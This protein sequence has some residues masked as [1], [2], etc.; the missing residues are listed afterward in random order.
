MNAKN[1]P[2][3]RILKL[4]VTTVRDCCVL[5]LYSLPFP[6]RLVGMYQFATGRFPCDMVQS[7]ERLA[8]DPRHFPSRVLPPGLIPTC[9]RELSFAC[10][11]L[12]TMIRNLRQ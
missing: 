10:I 3:V 12:L 11:S 9:I 6:S 2:F 1:L 8:T 5:E 4:E 7:V